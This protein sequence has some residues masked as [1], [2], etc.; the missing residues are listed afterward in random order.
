M[1]NINIYTNI[2]NHNF[3]IQ[4]FPLNNLKF[5]H[6]DD[7]FLNTNNDE[8]GIIIL[9]DKP[10][11]NLNINNLKKK[12]LVISNDIKIK[13]ILKKNIKI[14][15][16]PLH[17][18][19]IKN[20]V[21]N[22]FIDKTFSFKDILIIENK[23]SNKDKENKNALLTYIEKEILLHIIENK[24]SSKED[25]KKNILNIGENVETKSID[26]HLSRIRKKLDAIESKLNISSKNNNV[27]MFFNQRMLD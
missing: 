5:K 19:Q 9:K 17:P 12:Y 6:I 26:S 14:L 1:Q 3:I 21:N 27:S 25:L 24:V 15:I 4:L 16:P 18:H 23:I 10:N 7:L 22:F 13:K 20:S 2:K 8:G 11:L